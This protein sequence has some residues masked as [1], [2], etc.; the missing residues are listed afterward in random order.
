MCECG[1]MR[2]GTHI[3]GEKRIERMRHIEQRFHAALCWFRCIVIVLFGNHTPNRCIHCWT[4]EMKEHHWIYS[5]KGLEN[6]IPTERY[7][8]CRF[9]L[10]TSVGNLADANTFQIQ[11]RIHLLQSMCVVVCR[12]AYEI[13][14]FLVLH[15][16]NSS[17]KISCHCI[18]T[19]TC[20]DFCWK[21][22]NF[23]GENATFGAVFLYEHLNE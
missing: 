20:T 19:C 17:D 6:K 5:R 1:S 13:C 23:S 3:D 10:Q 21:L 4:E 7:M 11:N 2:V 18:R 16:D 15:T 9:E 22:G 12:C 8:F 14:A